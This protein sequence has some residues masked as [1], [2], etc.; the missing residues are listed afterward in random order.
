[1]EKLKLSGQYKGFTI[2]SGVFY[3]T[4][5]HGYVINKR[6][7]NECCEIIDSLLIELNK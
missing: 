6:T 1:M 2:Y 5:C 4:I 3:T 7:F